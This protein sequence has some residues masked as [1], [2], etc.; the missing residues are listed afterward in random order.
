MQRLAAAADHGHL[1]HAKSVLHMVARHR[2]LAQR[3]QIESGES[4]RGRAREQLG[5]GEEA[6]SRVYNAC[7]DSRCRTDRVGNYSGA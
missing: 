2:R 5:G 4:G 1:E 7:S 6:S 3:D